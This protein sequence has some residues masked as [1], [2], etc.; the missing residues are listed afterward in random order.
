MW[1]HF[2]IS[3]F[4][5]YNAHFST[6]NKASVSL[7]LEDPSRYLQGRYIESSYYPSQMWTYKNALFNSKSKTTCCAIHRS[8]D[9][10]MRHLW[11]TDAW[12]KWKRSEQNLKKQDEKKTLTGHPELYNEVSAWE[13]MST[14]EQS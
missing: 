14:S 10:V 11:Y 12:E 5:H 8:G 9:S 3:K 2:E 13:W 1:L 7:A 6:Y 4:Q